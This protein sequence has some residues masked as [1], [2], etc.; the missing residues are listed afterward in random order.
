V[1]L[2][3]VEQSPLEGRFI[4]NEYSKSDENAIYFYWIPLDDV[5]N[6]NV[7]PAKAAK[8]LLHLDDGLQHFIYRGWSD[9][10]HPARPSNP[11]G[12]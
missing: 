6:I 10:S 5:K 7:Y 9:A 2:L 8:L 11:E 12:E 1:A 3:N 4:S